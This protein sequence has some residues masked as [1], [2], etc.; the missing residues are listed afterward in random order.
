MRSLVEVVDVVYLGSCMIWHMGVFIL[1]EL[2]CI[3]I[4][5]ML[6][7]CFCWYL[8][9]HGYCLNVPVE[10]GDAVSIVYWFSWSLCMF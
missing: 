8:D 3:S 9:E 7:V 1:C 6:N 10:V 4:I 2:V 5:S